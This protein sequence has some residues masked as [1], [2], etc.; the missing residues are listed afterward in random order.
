MKRR[1]LVTS[2]LPYANSN[3]HLGNVAGAYL[4]A[5]IY[6]RYQRLKGNE[7]LYICGS[8]EHGVPITISAMNE[9]TTPKVIIDKYHNENKEA[10]RALGMSFDNYS[11]TS[12]PI[13]HKTAQEFFLDLY[14]KKI[15][16]ELVD[17]QLYCDKDKMFL[18]DRYVEGECPY[19]GNTEARGDQCEK[20]GNIL[21]PVTIKNPR[22]K[23]CGSEPVLKETR[24]FYFPLGDFQTRLEEYIA[25]KKGWKENVIKYCQS[26]F[27]SGLSDRAITRD[28]EWGVKVPLEGYEHKVLY[29]WFEAV[30]GYISATKEWSE[31]IGQ[32]DKWKDF[33][34]DQDTEYIAF[35]GKDNVVFH[36]IMFPA[37]LMAVG[38]YILPK[39]VPANEF[40]NFESKK[41]SKSR[42]WG[43]TLKDFLD[44]FPPDP[45]RYTIAVNLPENHDSDFYWADF[46]ARTNNELADIL[47]NF[48]NRTVSFTN[49]YFGGKIPE[50]NILSAIDEEVLVKLSAAPSTISEL[51][52][53]F[54]IRDG[55]QEIMNIARL[56]NKYFNDSEPWKTRKN[57]LDQCSTTINL[58]LEIVRMLAILIEPV[59][60]FTSEKIWR[61]LN[62]QKPSDKPLWDSA[63]DLQ[64]IAGHNLGQIE[65]LF[66]KIEDEVIKNQEAKFSKAEP[67]ET[68]KVKQVPFKEDKISID[69]FKEIDIRIA[70]VL[71]CEKVPKSEKLLKLKVKVG[72]EERSLV[73]GISQHYKPEEIIGKSVVILAN[74]EYAKVM[75]IESQGMILAAKDTQGN[76]SLLVPEKDITDG[77]II[78]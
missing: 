67:I 12:V 25:S 52:E 50:K 63:G 49:Q 55:V 20:C 77:S 29:V 66:T 68:P 59:L 62:L 14:N 37:I 28:M 6:V 26:W 1:I 18:P 32:P 16:K 47:G 22:C 19:C 8:D 24:H 70:K 40:F 34:K 31:S 30:L 64:L 3:Q 23:I 42:G 36:C 58:C 78:S 13:H 76:F 9:K 11:R 74:L 27:K 73:A 48:V 46:Q 69:H 43:I 61:I 53:N 65:I 51:F 60:P 35:I 7:V 10:F 5:D 54:K 2:A 39:N 21:T 33:W 4:P 71:T 44:I 17:K 75:G 38:G 72:S 57:N 15:L 45:L 41:F 56:G